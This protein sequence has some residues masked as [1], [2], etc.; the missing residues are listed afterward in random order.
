MLSDP[1]DQDR[2]FSCRHLS[3]DV[4]AASFQSILIRLGLCLT[5]SSALAAFAADPPDP[6]SRPRSSGASF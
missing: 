6:S 2:A 5:F 3:S 4:L 1:T